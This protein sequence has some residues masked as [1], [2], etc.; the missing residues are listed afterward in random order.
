MSRTIAGRVIGRAVDAV[1][2]APIARVLCLGVTSF[3]H[4]PRETYTL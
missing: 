4:P 1:W 2:N 3:S